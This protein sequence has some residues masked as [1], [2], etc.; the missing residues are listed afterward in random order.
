MIVI[1]HATS[2]PGKVQERARLMEEH[3][4]YLR[5]VSLRI[6][7]SGPSSRAG[8]QNTVGALIVAQVDSFSEFE[9][10]NAGD[11]FVRSGVY[12]SVQLLEWRP[13]LGSLL[14]HLA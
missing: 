10:F 2:D 6:L 11:P 13:S 9:S 3:K 4:A 5:E 1:R 8:E 12:S 7:L 14:P